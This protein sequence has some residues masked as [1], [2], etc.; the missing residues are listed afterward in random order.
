MTQITAPTTPAAPVLG[1]ARSFG[2]LSPLALKLLVVLA[3]MISLAILCWAD[4]ATGPNVHL[5]LLYIVPI[6]IATWF[7]GR[8]PGYVL[9]VAANTAWFFCGRPS[10]DIGIAVNVTNMS[11]RVAF[12]LMVIELLGKIRDFGR[13]LERSVLERTAQL[14]SEVVERQRAEV[15]LRKLAGQLSAAEDVE[16]RRIAYDIHDALSQ[17]LGLAKMNLETVVAETPTDSRQFDRLADVVK[18]MNDLIRQTR[19]MTF[20]L[21]PSMLDHFGLVPTLE[22]FAEDFRER[23]MADVSITESGNRL[24]LPSTLA[25]YMFRAVK[26]VA[27]NAIKHGNAKEIII[28]IHWEENQIRCVIDDDGSGFDPQKALAPQ[29]RRGL[30]LAGMD[31]RL[32]SLGGSLRVESQPGNGAR[33]ILEVPISDMLSKAQ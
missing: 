6:L 25:S 7:G 17:M 14:R 1:Y 20:D 12:H 26:E 29:I 5:G 22:R 32:S 11:I 24:K 4:I 21:H 16:R 33:V 31:E 3:S 27:N 13:D 28:A 10:T 30:G 15:A 2:Q 19:A 23:T 18:V 9:L 8:W